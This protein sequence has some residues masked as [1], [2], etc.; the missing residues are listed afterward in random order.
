MSRRNSD[1]DDYEYLCTLIGEDAARKVYTAFAG[2][3]V[4]FPLKKQFP[5]HRKIV[6]LRSQGYTMDQVARILNTPRSTLYR[7]L[8]IEKQKNVKSSTTNV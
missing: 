3:N 8:K 4:Y 5:S 2:S 6:E 7:I 1:L